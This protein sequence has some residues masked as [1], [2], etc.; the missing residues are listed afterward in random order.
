MNSPVVQ[1]ARWLDRLEDT[2]ETGWQSFQSLFITPELAFRSISNIARS[3]VI[4]R[5]KVIDLG[6]QVAGN[7]IALIIELSPTDREERTQIWLRLCPVD[8]AYLLPNIQLIILDE[9]EQIFLEAQSR[10]A[11]SLFS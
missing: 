10:T 9:S 7:T 8:R 5:C 3:D 4:Q 11:D 2:I 6:I 1:L